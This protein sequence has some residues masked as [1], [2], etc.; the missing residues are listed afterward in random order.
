MQRDLVSTCIFYFK[1]DVNM[2]IFSAIKHGLKRTYFSM[3]LLQLCNS[4]GISKIHKK[5]KSSLYIETT[6][7][8]IRWDLKNKNIGLAGV[9]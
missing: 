8:I 1:Y 4:I 6:A 3:L 5:T 9:L 2:C 7:I